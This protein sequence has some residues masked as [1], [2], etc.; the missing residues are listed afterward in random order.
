M[1][2]RTVKLMGHVAAALVRAGDRTSSPR[3][4][5]RKLKAEWNRK[6]RDTRGRERLGLIR[7]LVASEG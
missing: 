6:S 2:S 3:S 5:K 4:L 7:A 1:N